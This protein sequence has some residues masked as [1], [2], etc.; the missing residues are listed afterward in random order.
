MRDPREVLSRPAAA[1]DTT[2]RYGPLPEHVADVRWPTTV[3]DVPAPLVLVVHGG[4]VRG[5]RR[6]DVGNLQAEVGQTL[7]DAAHPG[8]FSRLR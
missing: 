1:P 7:L 4:D 6:R 5:D 3:G 2:V 8:H